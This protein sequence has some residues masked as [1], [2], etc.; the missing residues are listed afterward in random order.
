[1]SKSK[2]KQIQIK[3]NT[4]TIVVT[5]LEATGRNILDLIRENYMI[6]ADAVDVKIVF[7][8]PS[9]GDYSGMDLDI[10]DNEH[11]ISVT[12]TTTADHNTVS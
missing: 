11:C 12:Y 5:K 10:N 2:A 3:R 4:N 1:M 8:V 9:G 7:H 6:P